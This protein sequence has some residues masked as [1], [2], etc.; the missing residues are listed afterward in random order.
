MHHVHIKK[1][2]LIF[3]HVT[4]IMP[5]TVHVT[6][7]PCC[8]ERR[9][10]FIPPEMWPP[11]SPDLNPVDYSIWGILH[12]RIYRSQIHDVKELKERLLSE[13]RLLDHTIITMKTEDTEALRRERAKPSRI[14]A[15]YSRPTCKNCLYLCAPS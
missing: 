1:V 14:K 12:Q 13:W 4:E 7:S 8:K 10:E 6:L 11:N 5:F 9:Q 15:Q 3:S 2:P